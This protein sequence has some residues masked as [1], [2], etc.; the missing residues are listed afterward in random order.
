MYKTPY[1]SRCIAGSKLVPQHQSL[2]Y[3]L[4]VSNVSKASKKIVL[5]HL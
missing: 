4:D 2:V 1:N 3:S 5:Y